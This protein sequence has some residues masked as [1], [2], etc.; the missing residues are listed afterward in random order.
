M[1]DTNTKLVEVEYTIAKF[2]GEGLDPGMYE[3]PF[4]INL[5][6]EVSHPILLESEALYCSLDFSLSAKI[7][8]AE[9]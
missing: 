4:Q 8:S 9:L 6:D 5:P 2:D 7:K 1:K 3:Y